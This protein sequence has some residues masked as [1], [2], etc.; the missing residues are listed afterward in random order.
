MYLAVVDGVI[1]AGIAAL[2]ICIL[3]AKFRR[4]RQKR[5]CGQCSH[6]PRCDPASPCTGQWKAD[7]PSGHILHPNALRATSIQSSDSTSG[8]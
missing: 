4:W 3:F 5:G 7:R 6:C 1:L 8:A 2:C